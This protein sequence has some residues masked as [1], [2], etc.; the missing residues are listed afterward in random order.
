HPFK[1]A[2]LDFAGDEPVLMTEKD[3]VKLRG[4]ARPQ[5][6]VLPVSARLD[7]AFGDWLLGRVN[8]WRRPKAA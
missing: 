2:D 8:E 5:W 6:W 3:A 4:A 7:P 1:P